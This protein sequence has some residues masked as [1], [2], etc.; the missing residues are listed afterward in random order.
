MLNFQIRWW[1]FILFI[2]SF[3]YHK[4]YESY[5]QTEIYM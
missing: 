1:T 3:I 2:Y 5:L 4:P